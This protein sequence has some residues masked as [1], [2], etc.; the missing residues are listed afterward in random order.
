[1]NFINRLENFLHE[2]ESPLTR[3]EA[4]SF[5]RASLDKLTDKELL[6]VAGLFK[7]QFKG[8]GNVRIKENFK[9][10][11]SSDWDDMTPDERRKWFLNANPDM[12]N[13]L[14]GKS[15]L[16]M[17]IQNKWSRAKGN[18][19]NFLES[20]E[21][22]YIKK[23]EENEDFN[24]NQKIEWV[25]K[26]D[27]KE[28]IASIVK[29]LNNANLDL[30][31]SIYAK[32]VITPAVKNTEDKVNDLQKI[33]DEV[34]EDQWDE[35]SQMSRLHLLMSRSPIKIERS[36]EL[37]RFLTNLSKDEWLEAKYNSKHLID[38]LRINN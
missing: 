24:S 2:S 13:S 8:L 34:G 31:K 16:N 33:I 37:K 14:R 38:Y 9:K 27:K 20:H 12:E 19:K 21:S 5:I 1:M 11:S 17:V 35:M 32:L 4:L 29:E 15:F 25:N 3:D 22:K 23:L 26:S 6:E 7:T 30:L 10:L 18:I 28:L 36:G